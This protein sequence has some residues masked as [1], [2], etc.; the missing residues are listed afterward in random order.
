MTSEPVPAFEIPDIVV[1][2]A[3]T[4]GAI[5]REWLAGLDAM[6]RKLAGEWGLV[7]GTIRHGGSEAFVAEATTADGEDVILKVGLPGSESGG[8]EARVLAAANGRGY[9]RLLR[10]DE[11]QRAMLLERLGTQLYAFE[12]P[13]DEQ[14]RIICETLVEAW[15]APVGDVIFQNGAEKA[16]SLA[17][18]VTETW[19]A[20]GK[21]CSERVIE[22]AL[23][24]AESRRAAF[25]PD[26]AVLAHGDAHSSNILLVP[27]SEPLR[28]KFIDPDG[29]FLEPEYDLS[30]CMRAWGAELLAGDAVALGLRRAE[31]LASLT[32][33]NP[34]ATWEWGFIE[35]VSTGLMLKLLKED[36]EAAEYLSV[37]E[38]WAEAPAIRA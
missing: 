20:L 13:V 11:P 16:E 25:D 21:P 22:R 4:Q 17:E 34:I 18:F 10:H 27:G 32:N 24:Y 33:T 28:F 8:Q 14:I 6:V 1:R 3:E 7:L 19:Q 38:L 9:A 36:A 2:R 5:G 26:H 12:L 30:A 29:I 35:R 23:D 37:A 31:L 15:Q